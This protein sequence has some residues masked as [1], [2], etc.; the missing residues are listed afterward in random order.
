MTGMDHKLACK[1]IRAPNQ[2]WGAGCG[3][4]TPLEVWVR[5]GHFSWAFQMGQEGNDQVDVEQ[6]YI[7]S[8]GH[9]L[10]KDMKV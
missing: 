7:P 10:D 4:R 3:L 8:R 6:D 5:M 2:A 9:S 1:V